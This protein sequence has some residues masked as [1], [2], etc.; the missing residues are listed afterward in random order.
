MRVATLGRGRHCEVVAERS[1]LDGEL[2]A[3]KVYRRDV[4]SSHSER[5]MQE[6]MSMLRSTEL[7]PLSRY[8]VRL[9][10]T[11]KDD[12]CLYFVQTPVLGG[13]LHKHVMR[14]GGGNIHP[15]VVQSYTA[16]LVSA[17]R[18][19]AECGVVHRDIKLNNIL[20]NDAGHAVLCDFSSAKVLSDACSGGDMSYDCMKTF[21]MTGSL[22]IMSPEM[23]AQSKEGHSF[24]VDW[25]ALGIFIFE[26]MLG[27]AAFPWKHRGDG[28]HDD[29]DSMRL[30]ARHLMENNYN[31]SE[32][33]QGT[34]DWRAIHPSPFDHD[35]F[36]PDTMLGHEALHLIH[37]LLAIDPKRRFNIVVGETCPAAK[38]T[39]DSF[40]SSLEAHKFFN[41]ICWTSVHGGKSPSPWPDFDRRLGFLELLQSDRHT[42]IISQ[43]QQELF[44]G[45]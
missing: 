36:S 17:L 29:V 2:F 39:L 9:I 7:L 38:Q 33:M 13:S 6:K 14:A 28:I 22:H 16:E 42:D 27:G 10:E 32:R 37:G 18:H 25:W 3:I 11:K 26:M 1:N 41:G 15:R 45:F 44:D 21:T 24:P 20:L 34:W 30:A 23:A 12:N 4:A 43:D 5:I 19:L 31:E 40:F 8:I 35:S